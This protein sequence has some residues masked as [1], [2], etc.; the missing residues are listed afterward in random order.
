[1]AAGEGNKARD[2]ERESSALA[3]KRNVI[4]ELDKVEKSFGSLKVLKQTSLDVAW[5]EVVVVCGPS[6][7][8]KSTMLRCING[9]ETI[10]GGQIRIGGEPLVTTRFGRI[11][12]ARPC[13]CGGQVLKFENV[14]SPTR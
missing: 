7:S 12:R 10:D 13:R 5:G 6:G 4:I 11:V 1:M 8:G 14:G 2:A 9:L 3:E